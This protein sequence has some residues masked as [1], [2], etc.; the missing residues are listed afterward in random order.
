MKQ[1][2]LTARLALQYMYMVEVFALDCFFFEGQPTADS[3]RTPAI[4]AVWVYK[5]LS[6][7]G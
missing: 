3:F 4:T 2:M 7:M 6:I 1:H 5:T